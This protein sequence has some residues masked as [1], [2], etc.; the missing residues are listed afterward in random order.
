MMSTNQQDLAAADKRHI[1]HPHT[2]AGEPGEPLII[3]R[4]QG[5]LLWDVDG[6][7]HIDG[8]RGLWQ[9]AVDHG[10]RGRPASHTRP[11]MWTFARA[12]VGWDTQK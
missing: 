7:Q 6:K 3:E 1:V 2:I 9:C 12:K 10:R 11:C 5:P 4:A 8:T